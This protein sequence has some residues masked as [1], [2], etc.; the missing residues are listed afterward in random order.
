MHHLHIPV[1]QENID[2]P[3]T[4]L[5][6]KLPVF[7]FALIQPDEKNELTDTVALFNTTNLFTNDLLDDS[8]KLYNL[9]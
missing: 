2:S 7:L 6:S 5:L 4:M 1:L 8:R 3:N 9:H